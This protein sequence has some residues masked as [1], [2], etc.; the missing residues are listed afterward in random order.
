MYRLGMS[1][2][3]TTIANNREI[4]LKRYL[5]L[6]AWQAVFEKV[7]QYG[8]CHIMFANCR[9]IGVWEM[10]F[11]QDSGLGDNDG[12][13][14]IRVFSDEAAPKNSRVFTLYNH[15]KTASEKREIITKIH[16]A[17]WLANMPLDRVF[18]F[19]RLKGWKAPS[20]Q[21]L[22]EV[23][24][25]EFGRKNT[26]RLDIA[27]SPYL[28][29]HRYM[30]KFDPEFKKRDNIYPP[31]DLRFYE[32]RLKGKVVATCLVESSQDLH[33]N[34]RFAREMGASFLNDILGKL[35]K[36]EAEFSH[37]NFA[38]DVEVF[39][40]FSEY[41]DPIQKEFQPRWSVYDCFFDFFTFLKT[42]YPGQMVGPDF[43]ELLEIMS[44]KWQ[45]GG[46]KRDIQLQLARIVEEQL[47][48]GFIDSCY[49]NNGKRIFKR[50]RATA[51]SQHL[52]SFAEFLGVSVRLEEDFRNV[53]EKL[54]TEQRERLNK[55]RHEFE[56]SPPV[57]G[58]PAA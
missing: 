35:G 50:G 16:Y 41:W 40:A 25:R 5:D 18:P 17:L 57:L 15:E 54:N 31:C 32:D 8:V 3:K 47:D 42:K 37:S 56:N 21:F 58:N 1:D 23:L 14:F 34:M 7:K 20:P 19:F 13:A 44:K 30:I 27:E 4:W 12:S 53:I 48:R 10:L 39:P 2:F 26:H 45:P 11:G 51:S 28:G 22:P 6:N 55:F 52:V 36:W 29:L 38:P 46:K 9:T 49:D 43:Y 33:Q 24:V